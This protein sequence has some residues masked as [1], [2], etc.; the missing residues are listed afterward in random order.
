MLDCVLTALDLTALLAVLPLQFIGS[1]GPPGG[2]RN[3]VTSRFLRHFSFVS[4]AEM[5]DTSVTRIFSC[6]L[7]AFTVKHFSESILP[8]VV[9]IV[10]AT[11]NIYNGI[12]AELLPTPCKSHYTFNLRDMAK[13][14]QGVMRADSKTVTTQTELLVLWLHECARCFQDRLINNDDH[15]WFCAALDAS[16]A[17]LFGTSAADLVSG[18]L[19][20]GDFMIP[21]ANSLLATLIFDI[22]NFDHTLSRSNT[23]HNTLSSNSHKYDYQHGWRRCWVLPC[24]NPWMHDYLA[25]PLHCRCRGQGVQPHRRHGTPAARC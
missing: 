12:R 15:E 25:R 5:S 23:L 7:A 21:S 16:L 1:M 18:R 20:F 6:I 13:V 3:T 24:I 8:A 11:I 22:S 19:V 2:G 4:F 14:V 10:K 17:G 9:N